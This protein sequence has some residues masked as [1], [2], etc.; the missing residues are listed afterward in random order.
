VVYEELP[1]VLSIE[2]AIAV[3]SFYTD[4]GPPAMTTAHAIDSGDVVRARAALE[5]ALA[6]VKS[7]RRRLLMIKRRRSFLEQ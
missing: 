2:D 7:R 6:K 1:P 5:A 3:G 4:L